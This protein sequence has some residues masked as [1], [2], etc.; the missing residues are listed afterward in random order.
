[1]ILM[2]VTGLLILRSQDRVKSYTW[3]TSQNAIDDLDD[4]DYKY[5]QWSNT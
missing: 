3:I 4:N 2:K 1:M 5:Y